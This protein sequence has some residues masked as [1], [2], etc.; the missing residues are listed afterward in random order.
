MSVTSCRERRDLPADLSDLLRVRG[1]ESLDISGQF[2]DL[3]LELFRRAGGERSG[4]NGDERQREDDLLLEGT[5][6]VGIERG[7]VYRANVSQ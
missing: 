2:C 1:G 3:G 7:D 4:G 6:L 5:S